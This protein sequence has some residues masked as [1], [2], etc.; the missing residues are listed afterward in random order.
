MSEN[1]LIFPTNPL[2]SLSGVSQPLMRQ[3]LTFSLN[4][5]PINS[6]DIKHIVTAKRVH[7]YLAEGLKKPIT[8]SCG[9]NSTYRPGYLLLYYSI[10]TEIA[11][12]LSLFQQKIHSLKHWGL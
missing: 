10:V 5:Q 11:G 12:F 3:Q 9:A 8:R 4:R 1:G 2:V 7:N 6:W